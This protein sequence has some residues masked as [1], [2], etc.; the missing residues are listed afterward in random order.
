MMNCQMIRSTLKPWDLCDNWNQQHVGKWKKTQNLIVCIQL[1]FNRRVNM[2][3]CSKYVILKG[4][5]Q[6]WKTIRVELEHWNYLL[7]K[8]I[9]I[10]ETNN[11]WK[12]HIGIVN[13][14]HKQIHDFVV[15]ETHVITLPFWTISAY[16]TIPNS[17]LPTKWSNQK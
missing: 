16:A 2:N 5:I 13:D 9:V 11:H 12:C 10:V 17:P 6:L 7:N 4:N 3:I 1:W 8:F 14:C 15:V